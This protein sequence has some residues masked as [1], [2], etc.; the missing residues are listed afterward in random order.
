M[1]ENTAS[2]NESRKQSVRRALQLLEYDILLSTIS[3]IL[4][5]RLFF[6]NFSINDKQLHLARG[7]EYLAD[8]LLRFRC[9]YVHPSF[10]LLEVF[11]SWF[12]LLSVASSSSD[13]VENFSLLL[14]LLESSK[15]VEKRSKLALK[16]P[17][18][19]TKTMRQVYGADAMLNANWLI[20]VT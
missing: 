6:S 7:D 11:C 14:L 20:S 4:H 19:S 18:L 2:I 16:I 17:P 5:G 12:F 10:V 1:S 3:F 15:G 9:T 13:N 8:F